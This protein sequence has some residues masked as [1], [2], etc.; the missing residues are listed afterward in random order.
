MRK[1]QKAFFGKKPKAK[2]PKARSRKSAATASAGQATVEFILLS[3]VLIAVSKVAFD[4]IKNSGAF[5]EIVSGPNQRIKAMLENGVWKVN[6]KDQHP[7]DHR[8]HLTIDP[9]P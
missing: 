7:N 1:S 4:T 3:I 6:A 2:K 5:D 8:R 9:K